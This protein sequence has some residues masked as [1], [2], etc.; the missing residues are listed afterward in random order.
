LHHFLKN[1][2]VEIDNEYDECYYL[3][4]SFY[5]LMREDYYASKKSSE[6]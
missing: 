4:A 1:E 5:P 6:I 3:S 2:A